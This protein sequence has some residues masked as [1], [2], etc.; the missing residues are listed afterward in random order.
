M[1]ARTFE[2]S[3]EFYEGLGRVTAAAATLEAYVAQLAIAAGADTGGKDWV[4]LTGSVGA[5][6]RALSSV[7]QS[8]PDLA[9]VH[10]DAG[11]LFQERHR[12]VHSFLVVDIGTHW[13]DDFRWSVQDPR[14]AALEPLPT[15]EELK[16]LAQAMLTLAARALYLQED[17]ADSLRTGEDSDQ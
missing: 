14:S 6:M 11:V 16:T 10:T 15:L 13:Q 17:I 4:E 7:A 1:N 3:P 2:A 9:D 5:T 8:S 12:R